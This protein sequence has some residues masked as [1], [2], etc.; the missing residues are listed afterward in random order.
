MLEEEM[1]ETSDNVSG[2][3]EVGVE[4]VGEVVMVGMTLIDVDEIQDH[5]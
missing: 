5:H 2:M 3:N 1:W 4:V